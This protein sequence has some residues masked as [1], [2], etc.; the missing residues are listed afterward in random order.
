MNIKVLEKNILD[1]LNIDVDGTLIE[2]Y[3]HEYIEE[4]G[5]INTVKYNIPDTLT[6]EEGQETEIN[7]IVLVDFKFYEDDAEELESF[8]FE[9]LDIEY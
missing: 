5:D 8:N 6:D 7:Y 9:I 1:H 4:N 3:I 2:N